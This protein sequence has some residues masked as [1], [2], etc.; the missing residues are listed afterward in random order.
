MKKFLPSLE[1]EVDRLKFTPIAQVMPFDKALNCRFIILQ[2]EDEGKDTKEGG[3]VY[4]F[5]VADHSGSILAT[6]WNDSGKYLGPGD[7]IVMI[8][9]FITMYKGG[10]RLACKEQGTMIK[11]D[12]GMGLRW[13]DEVDV[14]AGLWLPNENG[15]LTLQK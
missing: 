15:I 7:Q 12:R 8:G 10:M 13:S 5:R 14:S 9:G 1:S 11:V 2:R 3:K 6:L 4:C